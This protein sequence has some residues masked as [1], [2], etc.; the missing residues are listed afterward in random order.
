M[1]YPPRI[2]HGN[3]KSPVHL[4][5]DSPLK[6][7]AT[8]GL[9]P[10]MFGEDRPISPKKMGGVRFV[11]PGTPSHH[12]AIRLGLAD[13]LYEINQLCGYPHDELEAPQFFH[14]E[15]IVDVSQAQILAFFS[16]PG[17]GQWY[18]CLSKLP[19]FQ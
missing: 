14:S 6:S 12:P 4:E 8:S 3:A 18:Q 10:Q 7:Q 11:M 2:K 15:K 1:S 5:D 19:M 16:G 17:D 9:V 13:F